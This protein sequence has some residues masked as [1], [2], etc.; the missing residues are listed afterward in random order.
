MTFENRPKLWLLPQCQEN[1][2]LVKDH[3]VAEARELFKDTGIHVCTEGTRWLSAWEQPLA[4]KASFLQ[5]FMQDKVDAWVCENK[6]LSKV[7]LDQ[8]HAA[9]AAFTHELLKLLNENNA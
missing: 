6:T 2:L 4:C 7:T 9:Y 8:P 3:M 1:L 5:S